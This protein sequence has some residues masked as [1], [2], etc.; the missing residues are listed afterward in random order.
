M[1]V[2]ERFTL[3]QVLFLA[4]YAGIALSWVYAPTGRGAL[5]A[6]VRLA[7]QVPCAL[8]IAWSLWR[9][10]ELDANL[11]LDPRY[12]AER[13]LAERAGPDDVIETYGLNVYLPRFPEG[14]RVVRV[15]PTSP[16]RRGPVPGVEEVQAP[17]LDIDK[18]RP[19][20]VIVSECYSWRYIPRAFTPLAGRI[21]P[22]TQQRTAAEVDGTT[23]F[24]RLFVG[25]MGYDLV[26]VSTFEHAWFRRIEL[27]SSVSCPMYVLERRSSG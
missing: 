25:E 13:W 5:P 16:D 3:S 10:V 6:P 4:V 20:F 15:G 8:L 9:C 7:V 17:F 24:D 2:D 21:I 11:V 22:P 12:K 27:H 19:R 23:F 18:R 14:R 1:R 26:E